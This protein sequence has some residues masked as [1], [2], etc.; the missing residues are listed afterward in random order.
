TYQYTATF[1]QSVRVEGAINAGGIIWKCGGLACRTSG[2]WPVPG[3][4]SCNALAL[5]EGRIVDYGYT[6]RRLSSDELVNCNR[7]VAAAPTMPATATPRAWSPVTIRTTSIQVTGTGAL[8]ARLPFTPVN[9]RTV[10]I[11]VTGAPVTAS[12]FTPVRVTTP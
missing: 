5:Q 6:L 1:S 7:G 8:A 4:G 2:P 3:V 10:T 12:T 9:L 11:Q